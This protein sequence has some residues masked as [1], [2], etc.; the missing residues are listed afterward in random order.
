MEKKIS[1]I[2][3]KCYHIYNE[4]GGGEYNDQMLYQV[5]GLSEAFSE[6]YYSDKD[7]ESVLETAEEV[8]EW[9]KQVKKIIVL[10]KKL[11]QT[12]FI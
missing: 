1:N 12:T 6:E 11:P 10:Q 9:F 4:Y 8:Y 5:E 3:S 7:F 2:I